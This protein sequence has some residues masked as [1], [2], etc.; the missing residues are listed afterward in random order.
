MNYV[1]YEKL[2]RV[3][4]QILKLCVSIMNAFKAVE[5]AVKLAVS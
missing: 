2:N 4:E 5:F 3:P 1:C